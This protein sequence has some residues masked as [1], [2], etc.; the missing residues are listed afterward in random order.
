MN[1][2][3]TVITERNRLVSPCVA[4]NLSKG[5]KNVIHKQASVCEDH[6][7]G[8]GTRAVIELVGMRRIA[9]AQNAPWA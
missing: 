6:L 7:Q 9:L 2:G 1:L 5:A 4:K 3:M 8:T